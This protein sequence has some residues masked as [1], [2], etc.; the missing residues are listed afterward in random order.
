MKLVICA[1]GRLRGGPEAA[2]IDDYLT[3]LSRTG[4]GIGLGPAEVREVEA[5]SGR[6][7]QE[8]TLLMRAAP[9]PGVLVALDERGEVLSSPDFAARLGTWRDD[10]QP[11]VGF[12]I[13]GADGL[14][15]EMRGRA[16]LVLSFGAMVWPH[17]L[18]RVMLAEQLYRAAAILAGTPYHRV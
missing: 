1:A 11:A 2:L 17:M 5:K 16:N 9:S 13:G 7:D 15:Q 3:R 14:T 4:R 18:V 10:G 12:A 6:R 8:A